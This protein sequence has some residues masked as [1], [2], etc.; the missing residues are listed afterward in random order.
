MPIGYKGREYSRLKT[1][2]YII[3]RENLLLPTYLEIR[4]NQELKFSSHD[5]CLNYVNEKHGKSLKMWKF[6]K[7]SLILLMILNNHGLLIPQKALWLN[8]FSIG[9]VGMVRHKRFFHVL[10]FLNKMTRFLTFFR[11]SVKEIF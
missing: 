9:H 1:R 8:S 4:V 6:Q 10:R 5:A 3:R 7:L 11:E 2:F